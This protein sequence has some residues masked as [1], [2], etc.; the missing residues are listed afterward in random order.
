MLQLVGEGV[1]FAVGGVVEVFVVEVVVMVEV[2]ILLVDGSR[3]AIRCGR[4]GTLTRR[5]KAGIGCFAA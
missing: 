1:D 4:Q 5:R 3:A 2:E